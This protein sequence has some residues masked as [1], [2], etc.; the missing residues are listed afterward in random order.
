EQPVD[1]NTAYFML[2]SAL[3]MQGFAVI[4]V[5]GVSRVVP[6]ADA[7]L[8]GGP[9]VSGDQAARGGELVTRVFT[10][11]YENAAA[12]VPI[13]RPMVAPNNTIA[14]HAGNNTL[15]VTDYA[16]NIDRVAEVIERIDTP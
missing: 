2:L 5:D 8:Q 3:R 15:V 9:V 6:E 7:K 1:A 11:R 16:D 14:A 13:L 12:L 4:D 10:L